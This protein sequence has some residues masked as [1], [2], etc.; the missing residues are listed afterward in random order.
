MR[1]ITGLAKGRRLK[2][3]PGEDVRPTTD[4]V[5]EGLFS[6]IQF[7]IPQRKVLDLFAGSGQLGLEALSRGASFCYFNDMSKEASAIV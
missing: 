7:D 6:A 3:L 1:V 5:K 4:K 2:A